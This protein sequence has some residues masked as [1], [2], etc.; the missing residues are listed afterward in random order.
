M[1]Q[2]AKSHVAT[3]F[4]AAEYLPTR[5]LARPFWFVGLGLTGTVV[6]TTSAKI[7]VDLVYVNV[8]M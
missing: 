7:K 1:Y 5:Q 8:T 3:A 6:L 4:L 2:S